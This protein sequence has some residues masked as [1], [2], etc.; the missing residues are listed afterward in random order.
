MSRD[1]QELERFLSRV[2]KSSSCWIWT[3]PKNPAGYGRFSWNGKR[4]LAHRWS[5]RHFK[6]PFP[7]DLDVWNHCGNALCVNPDHLCLSRDPE[8]N[9]KD[10]TR[11]QLTRGFYALVDESDFDLLNQFRWYTQAPSPDSLY[12]WRTDRKQASRVSMHRFLLRPDPDLVVDHINGNG[13]DNRRSNLRICTPRENQRNR[14]KRTQK[15]SQY[16]GVMLLCNGKWRACIKLE[17]STLRLGLFTDEIEAA[18]AY[19]KAAI[20]LYGEF[21]N[22]NFPKERTP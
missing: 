19:D 14:R 18:R 12:A 10:K 16:K 5:Y 7:E 6:G 11:I 21:A 9:P 3:G 4:T 17:E 1:D 15:S 20:E 2:E 22:L 8:W 13:L